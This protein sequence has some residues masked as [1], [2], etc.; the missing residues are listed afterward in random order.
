MYH[1]VKRSIC[2]SKFK[3]HYFGNVLLQNSITVLTYKFYVLTKHKL[4]MY[5][6]ISF[7]F[8]MLKWLAWRQKAGYMGHKAMEYTV[9]LINTTLNL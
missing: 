7:S 1:M 8:A 2:A 9:V 4:I 6:Q 5:C 3:I